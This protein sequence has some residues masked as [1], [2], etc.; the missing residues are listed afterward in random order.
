[1][2][3]KSAISTPFYTVFSAVLFVACAF[4]IG[5]SP[6]TKTT[7]SDGDA[8]HSEDLA[9]LRKL[10]LPADTVIAKRPEDN[11]TVERDRSRYVEPRFAVTEQLDAVLDSID[12]INLEQGLIDGFTIQL[13]SGLNRDEAL[14][15]KKQIATTMPELDSEMQYVQPNF[16]VR[17]GK[18]YSRLDAHKDFMAVKRFFPKAILIP[19]RIPINQVSN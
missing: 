8:R 19:E 12:R 18:Y 15:A 7:T 9:Y 13:Y 2:K 11:V 16:R 5:C 4:V 1:M 6:K 17:V 10:A 14:N 3:I